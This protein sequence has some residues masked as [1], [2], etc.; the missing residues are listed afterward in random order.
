[1]ITTLSEC[2]SWRIGFEM[3]SVKVEMENTARTAN[4]ISGP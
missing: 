1:M 3:E 2:E 4:S